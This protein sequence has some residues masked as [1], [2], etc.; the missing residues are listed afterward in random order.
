M[1]MKG[2]ITFGVVYLYA[3]LQIAPMSTVSGTSVKLLHDFD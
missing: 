3:V 2:G 1:V